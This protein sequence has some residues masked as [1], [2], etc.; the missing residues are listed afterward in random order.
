MRIISLILLVSLICLRV[1]AADVKRLSE[2]VQADATSETFGEGVDSWPQEVT[3]SEL[4][5]EPEEFLQQRFSL[6]TPVSKVCKMKG[7]FFIAQ[8]GPNLIRVAFKDY[9]FFVP[10]DIDGRKIKL[11]GELVSKEVSTK[12]AEHFN[13]DLA[14][15]DDGNGASLESGQVYEILASTVR[16]PLS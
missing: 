5:A 2:P 15:K 3:L 4:L 9:G 7:C 6:E 13:R 12:Q 16:V 1:E 10:T 14:E 11:I 8:Q